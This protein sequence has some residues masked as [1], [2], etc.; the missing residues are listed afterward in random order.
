MAGSA[1][2][3]Q[4]Y[5]QAAKARPSEWGSGGRWFESSRPDIAKP[6]R[7]KTSDKAFFLTPAGH[8]KLHG[9]LHGKSPQESQLPGA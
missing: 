5:D 1:R 3:K 8:F 4:R 2:V 9:Y 6:C 7:D